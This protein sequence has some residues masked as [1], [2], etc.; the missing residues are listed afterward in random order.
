MW[1]TCIVDL[2]NSYLS[3]NKMNNFVFC[4]VFN[5]WRPKKKVQIVPKTNIRPIVT[6][7]K[8]NH[9]NTY[10]GMLGVSEFATLS[11]LVN[12]QSAIGI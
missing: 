9:K 1:P 3:Q 2:K 8:G 10:S 4:Q 7:L 12:A 11:F 6:G 5:R